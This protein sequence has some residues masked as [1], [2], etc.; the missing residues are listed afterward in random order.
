MAWMRALRAAGLPADIEAQPD[1]RVPVTAVNEALERAA[2][3]CGRDDFGL[4]LSELRGFSNLGPI[5]LIA[6]D[7]PSVGSALA[8]I[9]AYLPLHNDALAVTR[10][11]FGDVVVLR[12]AILVPGPKVQAR[13]IAVAMQHRILKQLAG[14]AWEAEE[15]CLTRSPP[16]DVSRFRRVLGP[17]VRFN[18][19][20]DGI[21]VR[22][23]LLERPNPMAEEGL[24]SYASR[25]LRIGDPGQPKQWPTGSAASCPCSFP[26]A[27]AR[28][29][30]SPRNWA[31][32]DGR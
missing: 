23:D 18:A 26:A 17:H 3:A 6:R 29:S 9:E 25:L 4:R 31:C 10:E 2:V 21:V 13:D 22:S 14:P 19:E 32:R 5:G 30:M 28:R 24:R 8:A 12:S 11:L 7:E 16:A 1:W 15:V 27:V 20:F